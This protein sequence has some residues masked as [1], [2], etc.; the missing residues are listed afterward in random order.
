MHPKCDVCGIEGGEGQVFPSETFPFRR[1]KTYCPNCYARLYRRLHQG[2]LLAVLGMGI[3]GGVLAIKDPGSEAGRVFINL[4]LLQLFSFL[5]VFP[6]EFGHAF[7]GRSLGFVIH[8][9]WIG[10]GTTAFSARILGFDVDVKKVPFGGLCLATPQG[11]KSVLFKQFIFVLAGPLANLIL[12]FAAIILS[13]RGTLAAF[14]P[15]SHAHLTISGLFILANGVILVENFLP[16]SFATP[17]GQFA[18]DGLTLL[19]ICFKRRIPVVSERPTTPTKAGKIIL[20]I[21]RW[22]GVIVMSILSLFCFGAGIFLAPSVVAA[23]DKAGGILALLLLGALGAA[24]AWL[25]YRVFKAPATPGKE[26]SLRLSPHGHLMATYQ[27]EVFRRYPSLDLISLGD[28]NSKV[29][30]ALA[31]NSKAPEAL[32]LLDEAL[33]REPENLIFLTLKGIV[34]SAIKSHKEAE[35]L[36]EKLLQQRQLSTASQTVI[37]SE[38]L[39]SVIGM[40]DYERA[41]LLCE[42]FL[43]RDLQIH[44]K[45]FIMDIMACVPF[46]DG[47]SDYLPEASRWIDMAMQ[48]QPENLTLKGTKG[49]LLVEQGKFQE[50]EPLLR[51]VYDKSED[52]TNK[53]ICSLYLALVAKQ[54]D[55]MPE[56]IKWAT[57]AKKLSPVSWLMARLVREFPDL[58]AG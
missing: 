20:E 16:I 38:R 12:A 47:L 46:M 21:F 55:D 40:G 58:K 9:I 57:K 7:A 19:R 48:L 3:I 36:Y 35:E 43:E 33:S 8:R 53:G 22:V 42:K 30:A 39:K 31:N 18:S 54:H 44:E 51:E 11:G 28:L 13:P 15:G 6:H 27:Q 56:A 49:S 29:L 32:Q 10:F 5:L 34:L 23:N 25:A 26:P 52:E 50:A 37:M 2:L 41:R 1:T 4:F 14:L 45:V 24:C 17:F